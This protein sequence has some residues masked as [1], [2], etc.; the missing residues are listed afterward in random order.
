[1][2]L[3]LTGIHNENEFYTNHYL[4]EILEK[5]LKDVL[6][7]WRREKKE[8]EVTPP[9]ERLGGLRKRFFE[10]RSDLQKEKDPAARLR[11]Q[12]P[13]V[14]NLLNTLG[15]QVNPDIR[16]VDDGSSIPILGE[17]TKASGAPKLWILE[18]VDTAGED[19]DP[20]ELTLLD[21]QYPDGIEADGELLGLTLTELVTKHVF[22]RSEPPRW[23]MLISDS[24]LALLDRTKWNEKRL[25]RFNL[26]EILSRREPSTLEAMAVLAHRQSTCPEDG[27]ALLDT[28]DE[29]SHKHA[30]AVS[31]DL[32]YALRESIELLGNEAIWY[33]RTVRKEAVFSGE[34]KLDAAELSLECLRY[35]YRLLF[36][37]YIEARPELG[38]AP[39]NAAAYRE[40]YSLESLR[41]LELVR[42]ETEESREGYYL[43]Q[44]L[45]LLFDLLWSGWGPEQLDLEA[46][47]HDTFRLPPL[48]T[49][50]F[51]LERTPTLSKTR[52]RNKVLQKIIRLMSL[53]D[54]TRDGRKGRRGR[55]SY[56]QLGINQ[57]GA[58]YEAL[59]SYRG[60]FAE[61]D[62]YEVKKK[63]DTSHDE[64]DQAYF[65]SEGDLQEY[66]EQESV[67]NE[68]GTLR[69]YEKG[70]FIYRLAGRD[71]EKSASYYT[72]EVLTRTLVK[73]ALKD[74]IGDDE[75][76]MTADEILE[77]TVCEPAMGSA[78]FLNE[79]VN[80]LADAYLRRRQKELVEILAPD[81]YAY[82]KQ[83]VKM[84]LA[85]DNVFG[86]DLNPVA[87][88]LAE[89]SLWLNT[90][91]VGG[92][93]PWFGMQLHTGNSLIGARRQVF[94]SRLLGKRK[95]GE[96][97]W[98]G[99]VPDR[100]PLGKERPR[101]MVYHFLLPDEGMAAYNDK[102]IQE[103]AGEEIKKIKA[104]R[105]EFT[106]PFSDDDIKTLKRLSDEIDRL[107]AKQAEELRRIRERTTDPISIYGKPAD[108]VRSPTTTR[109]KDQIF[110]QELLSRRVRNSSPYRR[111][112][113][114]MDYWCA[115]WFWPM[116]EAKHLPSRDEYLLE[117]ELLLG[118]HA[119]EAE[120]GP[121]QTRLFPDTMPK[122]L[123]VNLKDEFG[124]VDIER[125]CDHRPRLMMVRELA[126]RYRFHHWELEF[127]DLFAERG[128]FDLVLGNPPWI[129]VTWDEV[130]LMGDVDPRY[131]IR[132]HRAS[133]LAKL[134]ETLIEERE[135]RSRY[136]AAFE[137]AEGT[138]QYLNARQNNPLLKGQQTNL[139]KCFIPQARMVGRS[140]GVSA[141]L[142]PEGVFDDPNG[143]RLREALYTRLRYH[144]QF[145]NQLMLFP[146]A[147]RSRYSINIYRDRS[148]QQPAFG[149][150]ANLF[151]PPT[152]DACFESDGRG[153]VPGIKDDE[154][155]WNLAGH[156]DRIVQ[157]DRDTL[158]LFAR[159][160][161]K[162][163][164]P[165]ERAR[166]PA[167]HSRQ[168]V[169]VLERFGEHP[170]RLGDLKGEYYSLEMWHETNAQ[171]AGTITY[172]N[173]FPDAPEGWVFSGPH[174]FVGTPLYKTPRF[175]C[176]S[177]GD[178]DVL[179]LTHIPDDYLPRTLYRPACSPEEYRRRTPR[180]PWGEEKRVTEFYRHVNRRGIGSSSER[181]LAPSIM[182]PGVGH[183]DAAVSIAFRL[184]PLM[185][186]L[187]G[188]WTGIPNDFFIK[189]TGKG[190][191]RHDLL[192]MLPAPEWA[193]GQEMP[194]LTRTLTLNCLT[195]HYAN[196]WTDCWDED[197]RVDRWA[198]SDPRLDPDRFRNLTPTWQRDCALRT[199]FERRQALVEIDVLA[200]MALGLTL[201]ELQT[202]YRVQFPVLRHNDR[203][204][205]YD[206]TGRIIYT[207][208][209]GLSG[210]GF[211]TPEWRKIKDKTTGTVEKT[212]Q[213]DTLPGGPVERTIVYHAPFTGVDREADYEQAWAAFEE[214]FGSTENVS[215]A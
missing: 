32:K 179:D 120:Q 102:V 71:R 84:Y 18:T 3:D 85:D 37:F 105:R 51:D 68:D 64:L 35:M 83:R 33:L 14:T 190:D 148:D 147:H 56:A 112:K 196:L 174:F 139:Y 27:L 119:L 180:V 12:R 36:L 87:T 132:N 195:T 10:L 137:E 210:V 98:L 111:L 21:S 117:L 25:L 130:G 192:S 212:I 198:K 20:L 170:R 82:E 144:F 146:I 89:V 65:V 57:L 114:I 61:E 185:V 40:G 131:A 104:W 110:Q 134:R 201:K 24:Q 95:K 183:I 4:H 58:V 178:Y 16:P 181:S 191:L 77:L 97:T 211:K 55:I 128:G 175:P 135:L 23:V 136:L 81:E 167:V 22:G 38:Y 123:A 168:V 209:K 43:D 118:G 125:L 200:A 9:F 62:L 90:I 205:Y 107:W 5:D 171:R 92:F 30:F 31:E 145:Q 78:A 99:E 189:A 197:F 75:A 172:D 86:V 42:L 164:T 52:L 163:G 142:H 72:P 184:S 60:F 26:V 67:Y 100:V 17:I 202:I 103:L 156:R 129:K 11:R 66:E 79:A 158:G 2:A 149:H 214:R 182:P 207:T 126:E 63:E 6:K 94:P 109:E 73:Y 54:P 50:L 160:Y 69:K 47:D 155:N 204:T 122:Q 121:K 194:L 177:K 96:P 166:L 169:A 59:L 161:D 93:V 173:H 213:D 199:D 45:R 162:E 187:N 138:Q 101:D 19:T 46:P 1:M 157:V 13:F 151:N 193:E 28:L 186:T 116:E 206:Q 29:S 133:E 127:A 150:I 143:G 108:D 53:S 34:D 48:K 7:K 15:Y 115:L 124:F 41:E 91:H 8:K 154:N 70:T 49:H 39:M 176:K 152:I 208:S 140:A 76:G 165:P 113:L 188:F 106:K 153:P 141:F 44:S 215:I 88:E 203:H 74:L 159:L 80:Q